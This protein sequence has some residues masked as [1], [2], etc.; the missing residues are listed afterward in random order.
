[1][2]YGEPLRIPADYLVPTLLPGSEGLTHLVQQLKHHCTNIRCP[3]PSRHGNRKVFVHKDLYNCSHVM[4]RTDSVK[5]P[6][7]PPYTGPFQVLSRNKHTVDIMYN[8]VP[9]KVSIE[10]VK[11]AWVLPS[12]TSDT[13]PVHQHMM[14]A[15]HT[16]TPL[17]TSSETGESPPQTTSPPPRYPTHTTA[18]R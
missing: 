3:P 13:T 8:G 7:Q 5:S 2:V 17:S 4:L 9:T 10:C 12:P 11:P 16:K 18:P 15:E 14:D 6:L 1:M